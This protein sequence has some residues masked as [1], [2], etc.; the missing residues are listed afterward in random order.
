MYVYVF[1]SIVWNGSFLLTEWLACKTTMMEK[2][3][4]ELLE[5]SCFLSKCSEFSSKIFEV[6]KAM[7]ELCNK[8]LDGSGQ[9]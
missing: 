8:N 2:A 3:N 7:T 6:M 9:N 1:G 5:V 4:G